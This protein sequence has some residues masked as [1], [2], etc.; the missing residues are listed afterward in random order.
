MYAVTGATGELGRLAVAALAKKTSPDQIVAIVRSA[1]KAADV[2]PEGVEIRIADYDQPATLAPAL[3]GVTHLLLISSNDLQSRQ[4]QHRDVIEA[5]KSAGVAF[6][7]YTSILKADTSPIGLAETHRD[8]EA[9]IRESGISHAMLR[10]SWYFENYLAGLPTTLEHG[11]M[12]GAAG[13]GRISAATRADYAEAAATV[14]ANGET[15]VFELGGDTSFTMSELAAE[16]S[17]QTGR[18]I[19][20]KDM[21][22]S[23]Y[24]DALQQAGLPAPVASM[25][26]DG[27]AGIAKGALHDDSKTLSRLIG[28]PT[29]PY[30]TSI[31]EGLRTS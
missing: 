20:Y 17:R 26:A 10:N 14:L 29:T 7:A 21:S 4:R 16:I 24:A 2:L 30:S 19:P 8:T 28:R 6:I 12:I 5:A 1:D 13:D 9:A 15:G 18:D 3:D 11:V 27:D 25:L 22:E 23:A 31:A